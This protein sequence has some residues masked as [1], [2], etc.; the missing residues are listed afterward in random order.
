LCLAPAAAGLLQDIKE[1]AAQAVEKG[2]AAASEAAQVT[3]G[4]AGKAVE[5]GEAFANNTKEH[6]QRDGTPEE[7]RAA[8]D[9][10]AY[11][12]MDRLF[13]DDPEA[14]ALFDRSFGYAVF[15]MRQVSFGVT[16]GYGYG[17]ARERESDV[18]T[19]MRMAT[20][21]AGYSFG[22][23]GFA[24]Q[25]VMLL[26]DEATYRRFLTEGAEGRAEAASM[27]G[28]QTDYLAK[29]FRDGLVIYKLTKQ[30]FKVSAGLI[31]MRFWAD[32][33]LNAPQPAPASGT[34]AWPPPPGVD[35]PGTVIEPTPAAIPVPPADPETSE[36]PR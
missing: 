20:G 26:E 4:L 33:D 18:P 28:H 7:Q 17:V 22:V 12:A 27:V 21:G 24:F 1:G 31:G 5:K 13:V 3:K 36:E 19:Y 29:E 9:A 25:L 34:D 15:E 32:N 6:F 23:G 30:G 35:L 2:R 8:T 14:H 10:L 16:A 11:R